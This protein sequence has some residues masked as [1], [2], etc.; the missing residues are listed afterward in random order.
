VRT[1]ARRSSRRVQVDDSGA[2]NVCG[3][4]G[5][6]RVTLH[7]DGEQVVVGL[8]DESVRERPYVA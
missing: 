7:D 2:V 8:F 3:D 5:S 4:D 1:V 6:L